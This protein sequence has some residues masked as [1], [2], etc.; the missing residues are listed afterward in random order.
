MQFIS[1]RSSRRCRSW[2]TSSCRTARPTHRCA[3]STTL[4]AT[5]DRA[6]ARRRRSTSAR[7][8][9]CASRTWCFRHRDAAE[10]R[11]STT[12]RSRPTLGDTIAFV[13]P[14]GSGKSTL[15]KLL[16]GLYTPVEGEHLRQRRPHAR[17][18]ATTAVRRQIGFVTQETAALLRH[19]AREP[20]VREGGRDRRR[21]ARRA[22]SRRRLR[23]SAGALAARAWTRVIGERRHQAL[24]RRAPAPVDRARAAAPPA[25][26]D[27]RRGDVGARLADRA[28]RSPTT[29]REVSRGARA[30]HD[31]DRAPA[32]DRSL[33]ADTIHVLEKGRIVESGTHDD[34]ARGARASTTR[35]GASRSA[36]GRRSRCRRSPMRRSSRRFARSND[37]SVEPR[38]GNAL[39]PPRFM[40]RRTPCPTPSA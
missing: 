16:V 24:R 28:A 7:S 14:S 20:A 2:A 6:A 37:G 19:D 3:T 35:C 11:A 9:R 5:A 8:R 31:P 1:A 17:R 34:A 36:S 12:S 4:M 18:C 32:L 33:H 26:A 10:Q 27:L 39:E 40:T 22:A 38:V 23:A 29:V 25:P 30:H 15:V 21:D 13:G